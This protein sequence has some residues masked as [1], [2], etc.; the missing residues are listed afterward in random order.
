MPVT[1]NPTARCPAAD[2]ALLPKGH[3]A[4][5]PIHGAANRESPAAAA[6]SM[7]SPLRGPASRPHAGSTGRARAP[8]AIGCPRTMRA[9]GCPRTIRV[10]WVGAPSSPKQITCIRNRCHG[11][12]PRKTVWRPP[13]RRRPGPQCPG[14]GTVTQAQCGCRGDDS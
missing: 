13:R 6:A 3:T 4:P 2:A 1:S 8:L 7:S 10:L 12:E 9:I 11:N 5:S 14:R